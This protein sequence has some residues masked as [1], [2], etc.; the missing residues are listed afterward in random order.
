MQIRLCTAAGHHWLSIRHN[1]KLYL[2]MHLGEQDQFR[3]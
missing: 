1:G 3:P 2:I